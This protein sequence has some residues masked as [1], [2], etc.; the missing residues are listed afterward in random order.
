MAI[1]FCT[2]FDVGYLPRAVALFESLQQ[3]APGSKLFAVCM[4]DAAFS[5]V[6]QLGF[7]DFIPVSRERF[8]QGDDELSVLAASRTTVEY[9]FTCTPSIVLHILREHSKSELLFYVDAD[10][11]F[12]NGIGEMIEDMGNDSV[13]IVEH[14]FPEFQKDLEVYG[15]FNVGVLGFRRDSIALACLEKWRSDCIEWCFDRLEGDRFADQKYLDQWPDSCQNVKIARHAG[16]NVAPWNKGNYQLEQT[17]S[18]LKVNNSLL[19]CFHFQGLRVHRFG[20]IE[21]QVFDYGMKLSDDFLRLVYTPYLLAISRAV[22]RVRKRAT[23]R[24]Y[25]N[26]PSLREIWQYKTTNRFCIQLFQCVSSIRNW[27]VVPMMTFLSVARFLRSSGVNKS[28]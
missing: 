3:H 10:F 20:L 19:I 26:E 1:D 14:R 16:V 5:A 21:P 22:R 12:F 23:S 2:Y 25:E 6:A 4:D 8:E 27:R 7:D 13:Y 11:W 15:K 17:S 9:Y 28:K 18:G 24:R